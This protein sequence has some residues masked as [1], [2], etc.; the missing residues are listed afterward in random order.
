MEL[1]ND[2][3][4]YSVAISSD[5]NTAIIGAHSDDSDRGS[6][7]IYTRAGS[8]WSQQTKLVAADGAGGDNFGRSVAIS[9]DGNTAIIGAYGDDSW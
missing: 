1:V 4:G 8:S 5:G 2:Y 9:S 7:Y 6:A 3:F